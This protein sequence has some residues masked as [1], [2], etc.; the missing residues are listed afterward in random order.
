MEANINWL[1]D[2]EVFS[3]GQLPAHSDHKFYENYNEFMSKESSYVQNLDGNWKFH[4]SENP[5][6]RPKDFYKKNFNLYNIY[7]N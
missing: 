6:D 1:D 2:P 5:M 3:V 4:F 7:K